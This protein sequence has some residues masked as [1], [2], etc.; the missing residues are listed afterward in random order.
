MVTRGQRGASGSD[1]QITSN[2]EQN[3][4]M[5]CP[6]HVRTWGLRWSSRPEV[7]SQGMDQG[8]RSGGRRLLSGVRGQRWD[9]SS[10]SEGRG[11]EDCSLESE[12]GTWEGPSGCT[13]PQ[14]PRPSE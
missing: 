12:L 1:T 14:P 3:P 2:P 6:G 4:G 7:R 13:T 10:G 9:C 8:Q 5:L 11:W